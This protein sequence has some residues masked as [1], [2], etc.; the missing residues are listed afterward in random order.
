[1]LR[2]AEGFWTAP[3]STAVAGLAVLLDVEMGLIVPALCEE[4]RACAFWS[5]G[6]LPERSL[7]EVGE[8]ET[9]GGLA[10]LV[11]LP[12][13]GGERLGFAAGLLVESGARVPLVAAAAGAA[14]GAARLT[15]CCFS[16][17]EELDD[18]VMG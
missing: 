6:G 7:V 10:M 17:L 14:A 9:V 13:G 5:L 2:S 1:M 4:D 3:L 18:T 15:A 16:P 8:A 11:W 12:H